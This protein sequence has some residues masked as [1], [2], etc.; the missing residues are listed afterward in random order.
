MPREDGTW[1]MICELTASLRDQG[2]V[3]AQLAWDCDAT[4]IHH[5]QNKLVFDPAFRFM[6]E[7]QIVAMKSDD[8]HRNK[9]T[10][11]AI[12]KFNTELI[13]TI[14]NR[15]HPPLD[16]N[17]DAAHLGRI[18]NLVRIQHISRYCPSPQE[19][20]TSFAN[21][22]RTYQR[23]ILTTIR[24][25]MQLVKCCVQKIVVLWKQGEAMQCLR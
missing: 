7:K 8:N 22:C 24:G 14:G 15:K 2:L 11:N 13:E 21:R 3:I 20:Q 16:V 4:P 9:T 6:G 12:H 10:K 5:L 19:R 18:W 17:K 1:E 25:C 23:I